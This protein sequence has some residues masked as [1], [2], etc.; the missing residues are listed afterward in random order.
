MMWLATVL[1]TEAMPHMS[2]S[3]PDELS[4]T[5]THRAWVGE[6]VAPRSPVRTPG[7]PLAADRSWLERSAPPSNTRH[8][9]ITRS[10]YS[11][12][13]YKSWTEKMKGSFDPEKK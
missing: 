12:S 7:E 1:A 8:G 11:W 9:A 2:N 10:L 13:N 6:G 4:A 3:K 5:G